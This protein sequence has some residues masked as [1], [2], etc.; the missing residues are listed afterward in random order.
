VPNPI[1]EP[2]FQTI[3]GQQTLVVER[4][5]P[6]QPTLDRLLGAMYGGR[7]HDIRPSGTRPECDRDR[8]HR[9]GVLREGRHVGLDGIVR[10]LRVEMCRDC[11]AACVRDISYDVSV[12]GERVPR[13]AGQRAQRRNLVLGWYTGKRQAGREYR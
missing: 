8:Q 2:R 5:P 4:R 11:G 9:F 13:N 3:E 12:A 6:I 10:D 7:R 1:A